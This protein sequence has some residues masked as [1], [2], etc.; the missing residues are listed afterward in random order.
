M[1]SVS[2]LISVTF[3][4][5]AV[6]NS[7]MICHNNFNLRHGTA[8]IYVLFFPYFEVYVIYEGLWLSP[9][10]ASIN[11]FPKIHFN[12]IFLL[13]YTLD[14]EMP[15]FKTVIYQNFVDAS[16][17][18]YF[19]HKCYIAPHLILLEL[20]ALN[21][22][23]DVHAHGLLLSSKKLT[24]EKN[25]IAMLIIINIRKHYIKEVGRRGKG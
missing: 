16:F 21:Y 14:P 23:I 17:Q 15:S 10:K 3:T 24:A 8:N 9:L 12:I 1:K 7:E 5:K 18:C 20:T 13:S 11:V 19:P 25:T 22:S 2:H 6:D 4:P